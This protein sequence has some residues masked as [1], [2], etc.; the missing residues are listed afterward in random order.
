MMMPR[1][2]T[3]D[4]GLEERGVPQGEQGVAQ[5]GRSAV[6]GGVW[7]AENPGLLFH[8]SIAMVRYTTDAHFSTNYVIN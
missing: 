6:Q 5:Q 3:V 1:H 8:W 7:L 2:L 4:I